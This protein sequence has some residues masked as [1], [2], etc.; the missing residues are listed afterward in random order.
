MILRGRGA[1]D[2]VHGTG[3]SGYKGGTVLS[4][5]AV[6]K[7]PE[8]NIIE[9]L[10]CCR[11]LRYLCQLCRPWS[12]QTTNGTALPKNRFLIHTSS[13]SILNDKFFG[14]YIT[15]HIYND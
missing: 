4:S 8:F 9:I 12:L 7:H 13:A 10:S 3:A 15:E 1:N 2:V 5:L 14:T 6:E 11:K